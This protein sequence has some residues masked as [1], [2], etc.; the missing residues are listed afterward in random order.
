MPVHVS[1]TTCLSSGC[2]NCIIQHLVS[3]HTVGGC[4][5]HGTAC[6]TSGI[7]TQ[8]R[9]LSGARDGHLQL[10]V[11]SHTV[12]GCPVYRTATYR[13]ITRI[14]LRCTVSKTYKI[15]LKGVHETH[16]NISVNIDLYTTFI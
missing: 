7:I 16:R 13:L 11:S 12:G 10:L 4:P 9:W 1:C 14:I 3:S 2:Q 6:Y 15:R 5:V 8:C